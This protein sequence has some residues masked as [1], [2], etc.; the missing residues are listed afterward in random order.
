MV[1]ADV[2]AVLDVHVTHQIIAH[3]GHNRIVGISQASDYPESI[4]ICVKVK[5]VVVGGV[6]SLWT[7]CHGVWYFQVVL[8]LAFRG[9]IVAD[10]PWPLSLLEVERTVEDSMRI[11]LHKEGGG[12][13]ENNCSAALIVGGLNL[14]SCTYI[15]WHGQAILLCVFVVSPERIF[16]AELVQNIRLV[17]LRKPDL[18]R[19]GV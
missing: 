3:F 1:Q 7:I 12:G 17:L 9:Q 18:L 14:A 15:K 5:V 8:V 10:N 13:E 11:S 16:V 4:L 6:E 19:V 2:P